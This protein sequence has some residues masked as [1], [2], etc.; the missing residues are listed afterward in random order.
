MA[1]LTFKVVSNSTGDA[2]QV[3]AAT[4]YLWDALMLMGG[5]GGRLC[6]ITW[7][8]KVVWNNAQSKDGWVIV[9]H[10]WMKEAETLIKT[11]MYEINRKAY[12]KGRR[13]GDYDRM[14]AAMDLRH[15]IEKENCAAAG[16]VRS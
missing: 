7:H 13:P 2:G 5:Y 11:R 6:S 14:I 4:T 8:G 9:N 15:D 16:S 10:G 1:A 12:E 3:I